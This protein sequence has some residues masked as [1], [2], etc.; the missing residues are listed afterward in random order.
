MNS[1]LI[2]LA[3]RFAK[4]RF[5]KRREIVGI[6]LRGSSVIGVRDKFVDLDFDLVVTDKFL[7]EAQPTSDATSFEGIEVC[8]DYKSVKVIEAELRDWLGDT[9]LWAY[10]GAK[11]MYDRTG[12]IKTLLNKYK[13]YPESVRME[14]MFSYFYHATAASPYNSDKA[15]QRG[16]YQTA[17][18]FLTYAIEL[19]TALLYLINRSFIPYRKWRIYQLT[20]LSKK[21]SDYEEKISKVLFPE[22][23]L[24]K[25]ILRANQ[26]IV[27]GIMSDINSMLLQEG[28]DSRKLGDDLWRYEP[29]YLP[30]I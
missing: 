18:L 9:D 13:Q 14:K 16:D 30:L 10:S 1:D 6:L 5:E 24:R 7:S 29:K 25:E 19:Y 27:I 23:S 15:I 22:G 12:K 3:H 17:Q 4:D 8:W 26:S 28:I 2:D 21:P 20:G 11:I